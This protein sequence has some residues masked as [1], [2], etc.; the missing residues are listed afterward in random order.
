MIHIRELKGK[1]PEFER[2]YASEYQRTAAVETKTQQ[3]FR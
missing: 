3:M 1:V 2:E